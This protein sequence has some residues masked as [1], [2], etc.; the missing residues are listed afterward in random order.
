MTWR[1][2]ADCQALPAMWDGETIDDIRDAIAACRLCPVLTDCAEWAKGRKDLVGIVAAKPR[3]P[4]TRRKL[5]SGGRL[6]RPARSS[7]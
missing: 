2:H 5:R 1:K 7:A 3:D 4:V 6:G